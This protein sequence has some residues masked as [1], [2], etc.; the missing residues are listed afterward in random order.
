MKGEDSEKSLAKV[1]SKDEKNKKSSQGL[2]SN[3]LDK[4]VKRI[5]KRLPKRLRSLWTNSIWAGRNIFWISMTSFI[6][7]FIP[8]FY[9]YQ[10]ECENKEMQIRLQQQQFNQAP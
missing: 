3:R 7:L 9:E 8:V 1:E 6:V 4:L 5:I 2:F 10:M